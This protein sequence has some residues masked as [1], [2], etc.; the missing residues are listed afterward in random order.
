MADYT[1]DLE[2]RVDGALANV[3]KIATKVDSLVKRPKNITVNINGNATT[4]LD[5]IEN[6]LERITNSLRAI[7]EFRLPALNV[8]GAVPAVK[9]QA[10]VDTAA[11]RRELSSL[12]SSF[13]GSTVTAKVDY[14]VKSD[15]GAAARQAA[16]DINAAFR[17]V[18]AKI[19]ATVEAPQDLKGEAEKISS[20]FGKVSVKVKVEADTSQLE[21]DI[22]TLSQNIKRQIVDNAG[23]VLQIPIDDTRLQTVRDS[24]REVSGLLDTAAKAKQDYANVGKVPVGLTGLG[25]KSVRALERLGAALKVT[26]DIFA[27]ADQWPEVKFKYDNSDLERVQEEFNEWANSKKVV[28]FEFRSRNSPDDFLTSPSG[29]QGG[30]GGAPGGG[31]LSE[32]QQIQREVE[33]AVQT[34]AD[35]ISSDRQFILSRLDKTLSEGG[36][37][38][39]G[40]IE[41]INRL[42]GVADRRASSETLREQARPL[43]RTSPLFEKEFGFLKDLR[44]QLTPGNQGPRPEEIAAS[45]TRIFAEALKK[46]LFDQV[47]QQVREN[48]AEFVA[49][50]V[51]T[52][53]EGDRTGFSDPSARRETVGLAK[54][55]VESFFQ[56]FVFDRQR[57]E[58]V[59]SQADSLA[60]GMRQVARAAKELFVELRKPLL[61]GTSR[62]GDSLPLLSGRAAFPAIAGTP[63]RPLLPEGSLAREITAGLRPLF[64]NQAG[65]P[66]SA[67]LLIGGDSGISEPIERRAPVPQF[68]TRDTS[69]FVDPI[70]DLNYR[71][72]TGSNSGLIRRLT[73][74]AN[75]SLFD[76]FSKLLR[77][78][79][80][81]ARQS[82]LQDFS[83]L[84]TGRNQSGQS[85]ILPRARTQRAMEPIPD[86][87]FE[88]LGDSTR[89]INNWTRAIFDSAQTVNRAVKALP[90]AGGQ[91][92]GGGGSGGFG[93]SSGGGSG[94]GGGFRPDPFFAGFPRLPG[95]AVNVQE[96]SLDTAN[97][98]LANAQKVARSATIATLTSTT[99]TQG[100]R[101]T[102]EA[103]IVE[104]TT[105]AFTDL[106][107][108][109][110]LQAEAQRIY[111]N[112]LRAS[113]EALN[114][115]LASSRQRRAGADRDIAGPGFFNAARDPND[116]VGNR[117][118]QSNTVRRRRGEL[119]IN[120]RREQERIEELF[121]RE[122]FNRELE[123]LIASQPV[124][125]RRQLNTRLNI[126]RRQRTGRLANEALIG[127]GFPLLFGAG[128]TS[129]LGGG[130]G[131]LVG[132]LAT[133]GGGFAGSILGSYAGQLF[134]TQVG[135]INN[136]AASLKSPVEA[137]T[138]LEQMGL[139]VADSLKFTV[140]QLNAVGRAAEAQA[141]VFQEVER[142]LGAGSVQELNALDTEQKKLQEAWSQLAGQI[143]GEL[144]PA[145]I[146][147]AIVFQDIIDFINLLRGEGN[148]LPEEPLTSLPGP[149]NDILEKSE[150]KNRL[151][152]LAD[153]YGKLF[154]FLSGRE[155]QPLDQRVQES[156]NAAEV[157]SRPLGDREQFAFDTARIEESRRLADEVKSTYREAFR[158]QR[159]A[160]DL[161]RDAADIN[162]DMADYVLRKE[163]EI[164]DLRQQAADKEIENRRNRAQNQIEGQDLGAREIFASAVGFEQQLLTNVREAMRARKEGE[165]DIEASRS[166]LELTLAK[167]QRDTDDYTR[168]TAREIEDIER[169]KLAYIR[170]V[171]DY[172]MQVADY[173]LARTR[174]AADLM[175]Q[176]MSMSM[177]GGIGGAS[178]GG[179]SNQG[180]SNAALIS[181]TLSRKLNLSPVAIAG[182]LGNLDYESGGLRN[183]NIIEGGRFGSIEANRGYG[184][185]QWTDPGRQ[186]RLRQRA[187]GSSMP[188]AQVQVE[189]LVEELIKDFPNALRALRSSSTVEEATKA[190]QDLFL[191]PFKPTQNTAER[192]KRAQGYL[193]GGTTAA[194]AA[195]GGGALFGRT[196]NVT[197][198]EGWGILDLSGSNR[199]AVINTAA[200]VV[201][202][203]AAMGLETRIQ[204]GRGL[205]INA[206]NLR[207]QEL[208]NAIVRGMEIHAMRS[209]GDQN[210]I[211]LGGRLGTPIGIPLS[212]VGNW[213]GNNGFGGIAPNG[214]KAIH[215][216]PRSVSSTGPQAMAA[217]SVMSA[218]MPGFKG[219]PLGLTPSAA[220]I[221]AER[222]QVLARLVGGEKEA[223][224]I[225]E[226][227]N[228][229]RLKGINLGQI[230]AILQTNQLP[231]LQQEYAAIMLQMEARKQNAALTDREAAVKD[232]LAETTAQIA[233][234]E[235]DRVNALA[236]AQETYTDPGDLA[237][238][239]KRINEQAKVAKEVAKGEGEQQVK[240]VEAASKLNGLESARARIAQLMEERSIAIAEA[241]ALERGEVEA[242]AVELLKASDLYKNAEES[243]NRKL[244]ALVAETEELRRQNEIRAE[245][246]SNLRAAENAGAGLR[247]GFIGGPA[248]RFE[249]LLNNDVNQE[250]AGRVAASLRI[251]EQ[252]NLLWGE[253]EQNIIDVSDAISG[254]LTRGLADIVTGARSIEDVGRDLLNALADTF[255]QSAQA[256]LSNQLQNFFAQRAANGQGLFGKLFNVTQNASDKLGVGGL[257]AATTPVAQLGIAA[258]T[259]APP[260]AQLGIAAASAS[261]ALQAM[262]GR[263][264]AGGFGGGGG[265]L[266]GGIVSGIVG[267]IGGGIGGGVPFFGGAAASAS[268]PL[269]T[270][271]T[272]GLSFFAD[273]GFPPVNQPAIVGEE[274]P[275]LFIPKTA[276]RIY[277]AGETRAILKERS[278]DEEKAS[279]LRD[280]DDSSREISVKYEVKT[281][282]GERYV[283]E[284]QF[285][286]G[287]NRSA[288]QGQ[289]MAYSGMRNKTSV[290]RS[291][292]I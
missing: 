159:Q 204:G 183:Y 52:L 116:P 25:E 222:L 40:V 286:K 207:G 51:N 49:R 60:A 125:Q 214:V 123:G 106:A 140:E 93:G 29:G 110:R 64:F 227:Q 9:I 267:G 264:A 76:Y 194:S 155:F 203:R 281:I 74:L 138:A 33:R 43:V 102:I 216:D 117:I 234:L 243:Q 178:A 150:S 273:G 104:S 283:T 185:A 173:Q 170:S 182:V 252:Q 112:N 280:M 260:V 266:L 191:M 261:T 205:D 217:A 141:L 30:P 242:T 17:G 6:K 91:L 31:L 190:F 235:K 259:A 56:S 113:T 81:F 147:L 200:Q 249:E 148:K 48:P 244:E 232:A 262:A 172:K 221:N 277:S 16:A 153:D 115:E 220:P 18:K 107:R 274:G 229:L 177:M 108:E 84:L 278:R 53:I 103:R 158:L 97:E 184:F 247:A 213:G 218:P 251:L 8:G 98:A 226:Q 135:N 248:R 88:A 192:I 142:R 195:M 3:Q 50:K 72:L 144:I 168:T 79:P 22:A 62:L 282:A 119:N 45:N 269:A 111:T 36:F 129:A 55:F 4:K 258:G 90:P 175:R 212:D 95:S 80:D 19:G 13:S 131:G 68:T 287:L 257:S 57:I 100:G 219:V 121:E 268:I 179:I 230:E 199:Q 39:E 89:A 66:T 284:D 139:R 26:R 231:Q 37:N 65:R 58:A 109:T 99:T 228:E 61:S 236:K 197:Q 46:I 151:G 28:F 128:P 254:S 32:L 255:L 288:R 92:A 7:K 14:D 86:P 85:L 101:P 208:T 42:G 12:K 75:D 69:R 23:K 137:L 246:N 152:R 20:A 133:P 82:R 276:G 202:N 27:N 263:S 21:K 38:K 169:R 275:E 225:L 250:E 134:D 132:G 130:L 35:I 174:E 71:D 122:A 5:Q 215:L 188:S 290:R 272:P 63:E 11:L 124:T 54:R 77:N 146:G 73:S 270:A 233:Q 145:V 156:I 265:G 238:A 256:L 181:D 24:L 70:S 41:V 15:L 34:P 127:G 171:E 164:F 118:F 240:N 271:F 211:D 105:E 193:G 241:A 83:N 289:A 292:G 201:M 160:Y 10:K 162:R 2:A 47:P 285:R 279:N 157:G 224:R 198:E 291:L 149:L 161:Q 237:E 143:Q 245:I 126:A 163:R 187:G 120:R 196:G 87:W 186:A 176:A 154:S 223:L 78:L 94:G 96:F 189:F 206:T 239:T 167:L 210:A 114:Q 209:R 59:N 67:G 1:L 166:R 136:L 44:L 180:N 165:A 253:L